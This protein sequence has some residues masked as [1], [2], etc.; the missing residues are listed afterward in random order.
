MENITEKKNKKHGMEAT[1]A[2]RDDIVETR[3]I[4]QNAYQCNVLLETSFHSQISLASNFEFQHA[5]LDMIT[6]SF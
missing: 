2:T 4:M 6:G 1:I 3:H 5:C